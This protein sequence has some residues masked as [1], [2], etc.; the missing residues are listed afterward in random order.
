[1][2]TQPS[3]EEQAVSVMDDPAIDAA[4]EDLMTEEIGRKELAVQ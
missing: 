4:L 2:D 3:Q 1:M